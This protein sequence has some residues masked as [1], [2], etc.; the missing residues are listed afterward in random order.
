MAA[1]TDTIQILLRQRQELRQALLDLREEIETLD[2]S[3]LD[4]VNKNIKQQ[5]VLP[6]TNEKSLETDNANQLETSGEK[7]DAPITD[8]SDPIPDPSQSSKATNEDLVKPTL[9]E[10]DN[11]NTNTEEPP[12]ELSET[13]PGSTSP[14]PAK[15]KP[16]APPVPPPKPVEK[17]VVVQGNNPLINDDEL[18]RLLANAKSLSV[19]FLEHP[20]VAKPVHLAA[21]DVAISSYEAAEPANSLNDYHGLQNAYRAVASQAYAHQKINGKTL[22]DS[23]TGARLLWIMPLCIAALVLVVF[24]LLLFSRTMANEMF[25]T[26]FAADLVWVFGASSAFL[27]GTVGVLTLMTLKIALLVRRREYDADIRYSSALHGALGGIMGCSCF[28]VLEIWVPTSN[29]AAEF[30]LNLAAFAVGMTAS[31]IFALVQRA[32]SFVV[33]ILEPDKK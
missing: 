12:G 5:K 13:K 9:F 24:P 1:S 8:H 31:I 2:A 10:Q 23:R 20:S 17:E 7:P 32:I 19:F 27:W 26:D 21:L 29:V 16:V 6:V 18:S 25:I 3:S 33:N 30:G 14:D 22:I 11:T 28:L 4:L 15:T